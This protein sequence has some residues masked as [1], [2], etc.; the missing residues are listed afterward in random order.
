MSRATLRLSDTE[1]RTLDYSA[2]FR[3]ASRVLVSTLLLRT[4]RVGK[5]YRWRVAS[6]G[7]V[8]PKSWRIAAGRLPRG[9]HFDRQLGVL[10]GTPKKP[11][12]Y[13]LTATPAGGAGAPTVFDFTLRDPA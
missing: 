5:L 6:T 12:R 2:N 4:G 10:S 11:G 7:G 1:G 13:R 8:L 3:V 9:V